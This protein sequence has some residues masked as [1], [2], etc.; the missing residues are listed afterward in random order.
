[1][2]LGVSLGGPPCPYPEG[3]LLKG[4]GAQVYVVQYRQLRLI[5]SSAVLTACGYQ[6]SEIKAI[7]DAALSGLP[8]GPNLAGTPCP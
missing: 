7:P 5:T 3:S 1:M 4:S 2:V 6:S 8:A